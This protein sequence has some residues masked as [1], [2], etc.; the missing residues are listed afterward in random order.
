MIGLVLDAFAGMHLVGKVCIMLGGLK[1]SMGCKE[2]SDC[3]EKSV[4]GF[5]EDYAFQVLNEKSDVKG[6]KELIRCRVYMSYM[7][8][9]KWRMFNLCSWRRDYVIS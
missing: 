6:G 7:S 4:P 5:V 1:R 3:I 2:Y 8:C 9:V